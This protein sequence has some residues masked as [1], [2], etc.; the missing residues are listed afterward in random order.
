MWNNTFL[1]TEGSTKKK[2]K[3]IWQKHLDAFSNMKCVT[4]RI[5]YSWQKSRGKNWEKNGTMTFKAFRGLFLTQCILGIV[6]ISWYDL[7]WKSYWHVK[8]SS[9]VFII[10]KAN[11]KNKDLLCSIYGNWKNGNGVL[12]TS[13]FYNLQYRVQSYSNIS[14]ISK[15]W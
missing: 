4:V 13:S 6:T 12:I 14:I 5:D 15:T 7:G 11:C 2:Y 3:V 9:V 1:M 10:M 8:S